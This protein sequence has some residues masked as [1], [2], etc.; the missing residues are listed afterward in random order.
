MK[1]LN[2]IVGLVGAITLLT[3]LLFA[4][5]DQ[6][7]YAILNISLSGVGSSILATSIANWLLNYRIDN[8][9]LNA[10]LNALY[11]HMRFIR[12]DHKIDLRFAIEHDAIR[13]S[14]RHSYT[15]VNS[16]PYRISRK[17]SMF[18]DTAFWRADAAGG[19]NLVVEPSGNELMGIELGRLTRRTEG[20]V[21]FEKEYEFAPRS[22][23]Q[24]VF[25]STSLYRTCD[26]LTWTVQDMS[27]GLY[28]TIENDTGFPGSISVKIN[29]HDELNICKRLKRVPLEG[30]REEIYLD[31]GS[32][33]LPF[34]GFE[35]T[36][37]IEDA[38]EIA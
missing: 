20:K 3:G 16:V 25:Q 17:I 10:V 33:I 28:L 14:K 22:A 7:K 15:L 11:Q 1:R 6:T 29:H 24:F 18:T 36:W 26:R 37:R 31:F 4:A 8:V 21:L 2:L 5:I 38:A 27:E 19:F 30:G 12:K 34:Q 23:N 9:S 35:I 13:V 32:E